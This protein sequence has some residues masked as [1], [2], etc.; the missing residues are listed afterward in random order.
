MSSNSNTTKRSALLVASLSS[1]LTPFMASSIGVALPSIGREFGM[2]AVLLSW[3]VTVFLLA[4]AV[5]LVPFGRL[6]DIHGRKRTFT[7]GA[8]VYTAASLLCAVSTSGKMLVSCRILQGI[9]NAMM[10]G[11]GMAILTSVFSP[12]ER[13]RALGINVTAVYL[14]LSLGPFLG[15]FLTQYLGWRSI[16]WVNLPLGLMMI[17]LASWRLRGEWA[18]AKGEQ[19]DLAGS[20]IY[21]LTL[22]AIMYVLN[23]NCFSRWRQLE[24]PFF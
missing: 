19:F 17:A 24:F 16:F 10:F 14:G 1:F 2:S 8:M 20:L 5:F 12:G 11:T 9:G 6:A 3:V 4:T 13:G 15:G 22:M 21:G 7:Y 18:G 23:V